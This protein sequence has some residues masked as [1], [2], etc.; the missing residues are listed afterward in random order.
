MTK[1][2]KGLLFDLN[3]PN[4]SEHIAELLK[5]FKR[6][7]LYIGIPATVVK[8]S[9]YEANQ[10]VDVKP[11]LDMEWIDGIVIKT[12][13]IKKVFVRLV[14]AGGYSI[15]MPVALGD[16]CVLHYSHKSLSRWLDGDGSD[17]TQPLSEVGMERDCWV[18]L[19]FGTRKNNLNPSQTNFVI[20][21]PNT[22]ITITPG[23]EI[24]T[25]TTGDVNLTTTGNSYL[26]SAQHTIDTN[27]IIT[28]TLNVNGNV[29]FD[30]DLDV[31]GTTTSDT[32]VATTSLTVDGKELKDH[33]HN[34]TSGSSAGTTAGNN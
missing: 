18:E 8:V 22:T 32:V 28:G 14:Q 19:G 31:T 15:Q 26:S 2:R 20:K 1:P 34:I 33:T 17:V 24:T 10:V 3:I 30:L 13:N 12:P 29:T 9:D 5:I 27:T 4:T 6:E 23:G 7:D 16:K 21:G 11:V 25:T